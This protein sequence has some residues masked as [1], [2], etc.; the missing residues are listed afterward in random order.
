[1]R[2]G[3]GTESPSFFKALAKVFSVKSQRRVIMPNGP[4][5]FVGPY[6]PVTFSFGGYRKG[7]KPAVAEVT[8]LAVIT[9]PVPPGG[10]E[11]VNKLIDALED[12][13]DV[14]LR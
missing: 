7:I 5:E 9:V 1:M 6:N 3:A 14:I 10:V 4:I 11:A 2:R 8:E 12:H 13:D